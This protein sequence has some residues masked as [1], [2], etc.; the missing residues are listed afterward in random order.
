MKRTILIVDDVEINRRIL[1]GMLQDEYLIL[2]AKNGVEA[3]D[4]MKT[5]YQRISA[6]MLDIVMPVMNGFEALTWI[7]SM[8]EMS[9]IPILM[10]TGSVEEESRVKALALGANDFILKPYN[11]GI[12]KHC[13][14]NNIALKESVATVNI[15]RRDR[16]TGLFNREAFF[17]KVS[18]TVLEHEAGY[19]IMAGFD[20]DKFKVIN[21]QYGNEKGDE[22][23]KYIANIFRDGFETNGGLCCRISAD[24]FAVLYPFSFRNSPTIEE[25]RKR[26]SHVDG[27]I[28]PIT[29]SIGRYVIDDLS[30]T[31]S[32]MY[33]RAMLAAATVKGRYDA[34]IASYDESMRGHLIIEQEIVNEMVSALENGQFE[35]WYQPQYNHSTGALIGSEA[36]ARWRHPSKGLIPPGRFI[37]VFEQN[38]FVYELDK[39]IWEDVCRHLR[40]WL[41]EGHAPLPVSVNI[42]RYDI[43]RDDLVDFIT[44]LT[45]K[46]SLPVE[47]LRLEITES[48]FSK[49]ASQ[50]I[51]VVKRLIDFGFTVEIDDFGS[52]YSSLNTL[53]DVPAQVLKLDMKFLESSENSQRGGNIV[54]SIVRMAK[55]LDMAVIAEGV[56]T[57]RQADFLK[58]IGCNYIQGYLYAKPMP[59]HDYENISQSRDKEERLL[60]LE[61]VE[62]LDNNAFWDPDSLDTLIFNS[63]IG[64]ACIYEYLDG[65]IELLRATDKYAQIIGSVGMTVEDALR[66]NWAEHLEAES[67]RRVIEDIQTSIETKREVTGE[68][69]FLDLP[70][71]PHETYLRSTMRVIASAGNRCLVY[72]T[73]ENITLQ[74]KAEQREHE[75]AEEMRLIMSNVN[76]GICAAEYRGSGDIRI[77][78]ANDQF[79]AMYGY[80][81]EQFETELPS[82]LDAILP[83]DREKTMKTVSELV[84]NGGMATYEYRCKKR[85]GSVINVCCNNSVAVFSGI[86][87][88]VLLSVTT[89]TTELESAKRM[90]RSTAQQLQALLGSMNSGFSAIVVDK[91]NK[92]HIVFANEKYYTM[93]GYTKEQIES[94]VDYV[95]RIIHPD[96]REMAREKIL[97]IYENHIPVE[98]EYRCVKR[99]GSIVYV[100]GNKSVTSIEGYDEEVLIS[101]ITDIT[102]LVDAKR[103]TEKI[104]QQMQA[105]M[106][107]V[108]Q[109]I[110][111]SLMNK[112]S[113][114][115]IF[116]NDRYFEM[117]GYTR[118]QYEREI[119]NPLTSI[120]PDER[121]RVRSDI[122]RI[123]EE[124]TSDVLEFRAMRRDGEIRYLRAAISVARFTGI[125]GPVQLAIYRDITDMK[126]SELRE[127]AASEQV[128]VILSDIICG[129][130][131]TVLDEEGKVKFLFSNDR[132]YEIHGYT[133]EEFFAEFSDAM[134]IIH[135]NDRERVWRCSVTT[136]K[137]RVPAH[138]E[139]RIIPRDGSE[140]WIRMDISSTHFT[141]IDQNVNLCCY[142]DITSEK[143]VERELLDNLPCGAALYEYDGKSISV[144][145]INKRYWEWVNR[146]AGENYEISFMNAIHK[147]DRAL[148]ENE[149][150]AAIAEN[151]DF[152]LDLRVL[153][154][155][156]SYRLFRVNGKL[157]KKENGIFSIY[158]TYTAVEH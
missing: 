35:A 71:C 76:G 17:D 38:G 95:S 43:F 77:I 132:F 39:Y 72:C 11:T 156:D 36:L 8:Q 124:W 32:A 138:V 84:R 152:L 44:G 5:E 24:N 92:G 62:N 153:H 97:G 134:Q 31:P 150:R 2:E 75:L 117:L 20:I 50:I 98:L 78:F 40:K 114:S 23:L 73:N 22:V 83:E 13:L 81:R 70:N 42:S 33:D 130:T 55:W 96:D 137:D 109:G 15:L 80:T 146:N 54:E 37:P 58:T 129:L 100:R 144:K 118:E 126:E 125:D 147:D 149:L 140:R 53:K 64:G 52:G 145:Y 19:Y 85:D 34:Q 157:V 104:L 142:T 155:Q 3:C 158:T 113:F 6:V 87:G 48:A 46:Y 67:G 120:V 66:L 91:E 88:T 79:Y 7:R 60:S 82:A 108:D 25:I 143:R 154:G 136:Y 94:E 61:T 141:G 131:A 49:S 21:D 74:R 101:V 28:S 10:I 1:T 26:A 110:T 12:I 69:I 30:L 47:L 151:R 51:A 93:F 68:Y 14:V 16:L 123:S 116:A 128:Q 111:A 89:D 29:F 133:R 41:D 27:L 148:I 121:A 115:F 112:D 107:N 139:Y 106:N 63:Y 103:H 135:P 18:E 9:Q 127:H 56:E 86:T 65:K 57:T 90:E 99:D 59:A 122:K 45:K 105:I 4:I 102:E 119:D